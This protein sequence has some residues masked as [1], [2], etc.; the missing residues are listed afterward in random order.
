MNI[1]YFSD[2]ERIILIGK[3]FEEYLSQCIPSELLS[4]QNQINFKIKTDVFTDNFGCRKN[5]IFSLADYISTLL[6]LCD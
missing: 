1:W 6:T 4:P 3:C 2:Y 5:T